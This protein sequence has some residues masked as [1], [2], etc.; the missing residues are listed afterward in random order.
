MTTIFL[1]ENRPLGSGG[2]TGEEK[3]PMFENALTT[4]DTDVQRCGGKF[5]N[6]TIGQADSGAYCAGQESPRI[7]PGKI[8]LIK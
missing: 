3:I 1:F 6:Y 5:Q 4:I 2:A 7:P 8:A